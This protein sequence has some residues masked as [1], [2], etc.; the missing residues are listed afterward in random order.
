MIDALKGLVIESPALY[1]G[2]GGLIIGTVFGYIVFI[3]NFCTMGSISDI[4]NFGDYRRFR[5]WILATATAI[6]GATVVQMAG[7]ADLTGSLYLTPSFNWLGNIA[8]GLIFGFG[9]VFAGGCTSRNLVRAGGGDLRSLMVLIVVGIFG[10]MTIGGLLGPLRV[11]IFSPVTVNLG[12][13]GLDSQ[14][15]G[16]ILAAMTGLDSALAG[17]IVLAVLLAGLLG[18]VLKDRGFRNSPTHIIAGVGIGLCVTAGWLL[19]GLAQ[20]DFADV[21]VALASL[22]YVRPS[23]DTIDYLMRFTAYSAPTFAVV[24]TFGALLGGFIGAVAHGKFAIATFAD[25]KDTRRNLFGA[26]L[27]GIGGVVA[28]GCT[29]GQAISGASTLALGSY[30]TFVFIVVGG[31]A[32]MKF[33]EFLLMR[34]A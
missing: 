32:G 30:I 25:A 31:I 19:T 8:G 12:D 20:D 27:M 33:F 34:E 6:I 5:S 18:Y 16:D 13:Y 22:T 26:A 14:H 21:P 1:V 7:I 23:G 28:L 3:T 24:T 9:M 29:V 4:M 11:A 2:F 17:K 10:Y 15:S